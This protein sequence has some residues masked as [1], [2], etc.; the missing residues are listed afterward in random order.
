MT[1]DD[2]L[3]YVLTRAKGC[4]TPIA[5]LNIRLA[6]IEF[7][8]KTLL[9]REYQSGVTTVANQTAYNY[10]PAAGQSVSML[11]S[12][13]VYAAGST[14]DYDDIDIVAAEVGKLRDSAGYTQDYAYGT[15]QGFELRPA[16]DAGLRIVTY[17]VV[18]PTLS[19]TTVPDA[20][21]QYAED[22]ANG[23]LSRLL[24]MKDKEYTDI[25]GAA[26]S[27]TAWESAIA[28]AKNDAL[29]GS[30]RTTVRSTKVWM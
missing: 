29:T 17:S 30:A 13:Q 26:S 5:L 18:T 24:A 2:F 14:T 25:A 21:S 1:L 22:I 20:F 3:P 23:A 28:D 19:G 15:L 11:L 7:C 6:L 4:P 27:K 12:M 8:S 9:W 10:A 16:R